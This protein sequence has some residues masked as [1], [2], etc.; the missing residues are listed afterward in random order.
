MKYTTVIFDLDGTLLDT[1]EDL[2]LATN[3]TMEAFGWPDRTITEV[4]A[5][6]GNGTA[7][8][9]KCAAPQDI[10]EETFN[11]AL[12]AQQEYYTAH[13][14]DT[15]RPYD[16]IMGLLGKLKEHGIKM[17]IVSNKPQKAVESLRDLYFADYIDICVGD[18]PAVRRKPQ[19]DTVLRSIELLGSK[20]EE[21]V[22]VGDSEVDVMTAANAGIDCIAVSW[23][24]RDLIQ[25]VEAGAQTIC[26]DTNE[27]FKEICG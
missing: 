11:K 15:T 23:G 16:G 13:C 20:R 17:A 8:L 25:L 22:Y 27:V 2:W 18:S 14:T 1:L 12:A 26:K 4:R 3:H 21:S 10:D 19:P 6:V 24:F 5:F 9:V 7:R